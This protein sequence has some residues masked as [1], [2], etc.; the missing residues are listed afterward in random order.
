MLLHAATRCYMLLHV[1]ARCCMLLHAATSRQLLLVNLIHAGDMPLHA[2][3]R[4]CAKAVG[5]GIGRVAHSHAEDRAGVVQLS[6]ELRRG[7]E[8]GTVM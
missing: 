8:A 1:A 2:V 5:L 6:H 4:R 7:D 3:T